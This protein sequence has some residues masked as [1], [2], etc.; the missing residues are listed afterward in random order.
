[1]SAIR[2]TAGTSLARTTVASS[3]MA[4]VTPKPSCLMFVAE[5]VRKDANTMAMRSA[6]AVMIRPV[7]CRPK[8][9]ASD[10]IPRH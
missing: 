9:T 5:L 1:M 4:T 8:A 2:M 10:W 7:R 3:R 6:A